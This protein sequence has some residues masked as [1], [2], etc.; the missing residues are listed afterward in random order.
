MPISRQQIYEV[1]L[2][3]EKAWNAHDLTRVMNLFHDEIYFEHWHEASVLGK[4][5]LSLAWTPWFENHGNF[6]FTTEDLFID[7]IAQKA[8][9]QWHLTWPSIEKGYEGALE[10]RRGVDVLHFKQ[11][12]IISKL[13]YS[14]T[15]LEI[16]GKTAKCYYSIQK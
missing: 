15:K 1:M 9:Y 14:K 7:E 8:L 10:K 3:W 16:S 11:G 4:D 6:H 2:E 12:K 13:S 5:K